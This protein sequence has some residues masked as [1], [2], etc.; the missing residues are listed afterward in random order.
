MI[1]ISA[2]C[3][4]SVERIGLFCA[5]KNLPLKSRERL[6]DVRGEITPSY[7]L[8]FPFPPHR[9]DIKGRVILRGPTDQVKIPHAES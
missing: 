4:F 9:M 2:G 6:D 3:W 1:G 8:V 7:S 5:K